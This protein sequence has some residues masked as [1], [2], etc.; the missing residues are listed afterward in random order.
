MKV[1]YW[2]YIEKEILNLSDRFSIL[3][4]V[5]DFFRYYENVW[6]WIEGYSYKLNAKVN[7]SRIHNFE[8]GEYEKPLCIQLEFQGEQDCKIVDEIGKSI[9]KELKT[10]VMNGE[11]NHLKGTDYEYRN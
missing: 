9:A 5:T 10:P 2:I 3:F 11:I 6:E 7:I 4:G 1:N 8:Q